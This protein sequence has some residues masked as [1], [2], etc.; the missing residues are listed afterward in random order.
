[1]TK[2]GTNR[3]GPSRPAFTLIE[4]LVVIAIIGILIG[5]LL[6]AIQKIRELANQLQCQNNLHQM[7]LAMHTYHDANKRFPPAYVH[8]STAVFGAGNSQGVRG[9]IVDGGVNRPTVPTLPGWGWAALLLPYV[10][11]G[12]LAAQIRYELSIG[13][14]VQTPARTTLLP[15]YICPTD[16][17]AG[18]YTLFNER[19]FF[20]GKAATNSYATCYG[21]PNDGGPVLADPG[22]G[23]FY[24]NSKI[25][26][27]DILDGASN[28][29]MVGER[30]ALFARSPWA[31]A[32]NFGVIQTS[33]GAPVFI[34]TRDPAPTLVSARIARRQINDPYSEVYDFFSPHQDVSMWLFADGSVHR[35][36]NATDLRVLNALCT[37][38]G[39]EVIGDADY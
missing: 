35:L 20:L 13:D 14:D 9:Q 16:Q 5:L 15:I 38:A 22:P 12:N 3:T 18:V 33:L 26:L 30:A 8:G 2:I 11:Q 25:R 32:L 7:G 36:N 34:S 10:E 27:T 31:G 1:M 17:G 21:G 24:C 29:I 6:P 28:T 4:L 37:R 39:G 19:G 23:M